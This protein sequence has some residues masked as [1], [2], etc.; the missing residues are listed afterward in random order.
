[1]KLEKELMLHSV[2]WS[3]DSKESTINVYNGV[4]DVLWVMSILHLT[5][6][7]HDGNSLTYPVCHIYM[8]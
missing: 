6:S 8:I 5:M 2:Y 7:L 3:S 4:L 1:M